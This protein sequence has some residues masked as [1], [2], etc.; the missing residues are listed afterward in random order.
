MLASLRLLTLSSLLCLGLVTACVDH[1]PQ[2]S[3]Y[4]AIP[5]I[6][7]ERALIQEGIDDVQDG[8]LLTANAQKVDALQLLNKGIS[9]LAGIEAFTKLS[10]LYC[11]QNNLTTLDVSRNTALQFLYCGSNLLTAIDISKNPRL[12]F[13]DCSNNKLTMLDVSK[14]T[15]LGFVASTGNSIR[16]ICVYSLSQPNSSWLK[17]QSTTYSICP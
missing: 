17:D 16:T 12:I 9:N 2:P 1:T 11:S 7:F 14:N 4:T 3:L 13:F 15:A 10:T 8:R 5:D 6:N